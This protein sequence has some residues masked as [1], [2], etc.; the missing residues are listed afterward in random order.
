MKS[1]ENRAILIADLGYGDAGKGSVVD[2]LTRITHA[3]A[4][5]RYNG[6][7]QA[8]HNV[9][10]PDGRHHTFSQFG[11]GTF[12]PGTRTHLSRFMMVHPLA[13]LAEERHLASLGVYGAF[14]RM[15]IDRRALVT[16]PFQQAANR[17]KE[18]ARGDARHG[19]CGMGVGETMSD[20]LAHGEDVL[21]AGDL[22]SHAVVVKKLKRM[23]EMK[24]SQLET[25]LKDAAPRSAAIAGES[26]CFHDPSF[27]E[28]T[29]DLYN[30]FARQVNMVDADY[31]GRLLNQPRVTIFE[32]AQ[33]VLLDEWYGFFPYNSW[34]TL[35]LKNADILL[36][37]NHFAGGTLRLGL[38]RGYATRHGAGPFVTEDSRLTS[39]IPD[40][41]NGDNLWQR[42]FRVG[43][44]DFLALRYALNV[45]G[46]M[47][48][49][50]LTNLDRMTDLDEW[51]TCNRYQTSERSAGMKEYFDF[52][53]S[54]IK[55]IKVPAD[56]TDLTKQEG[57]TRA[58]FK[59]QP[60]Y[61]NSK[62]DRSA[63]IELIS[64]ALGLPVELTSSGPTALEKEPSKILREYAGGKIKQMQPDAAACFQA[65][66]PV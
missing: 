7:A 9:I 66:I 32:G 58:L 51:Q 17:I 26:N 61:E 40:Y 29:A 25:I 18:M 15:S 11:S 1:T 45:A 3:Q 59:L 35:T 33:G 57:L 28:A 44:L 12:V 20:W 27:I 47:D 8:A 64:Q 54:Q 31:L 50:V 41:H 5:I 49:L 34:S 19:S 10:T 38:T 6:G 65:R 2:Y 22:G 37:E 30:Y 63:Y 53:G 55:D 36:E 23:R 56:P 21:F 24:L 13:M 14:A 48:G 16:T 39:R 52:D 62:K 4:V 43:C 46:K 42:E 60:V